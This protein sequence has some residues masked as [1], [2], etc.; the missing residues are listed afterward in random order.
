MS[1]R[2]LARAAAAVLGTL[3]ILIGAPFAGLALV[4]VESDVAERTIAKREAVGPSQ[5]ASKLEDDFVGVLLPPRMTDMLARAEATVLE[6][7]AKAGQHVQE[8]DVIVVLDPRQ[9]QHALAMTESQLQTARADV[10]A[11]ASELTA[12]RQ[13]AS[14]RAATVRIHGKLTRIVSEEELAQ[15]RAEVERAAAR[16]TSTEASVQEQEAKVDQLRLTL[17]DRTLR[18]PFD[19][20]VS[21]VN[22]EAAS[23]VHADDVVARVVGGDG[24]RA[25]IAVPEESAAA[26]QHRTVDIRVDDV[27][28]AGH[29]DQTSPEPEPSSRA[30]LV[31]VTVDTAAIS[32]EMSLSL[33]GRPIR[34]SF[35][36]EGD[37]ASRE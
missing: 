14:R 22:F 15:A 23:Q 20:V 2:N 34:A 27:A 35:T 12:T 18:A 17:A 24:L 11:A 26:L 6:V 16:V 8:G 3:S 10:A 33:A 28:L 19:G 30:F 37:P 13:R 7:H 1:I 32:D 29:I 9:D 5:Q 4:T 31:E 25:R 21:F 36:R